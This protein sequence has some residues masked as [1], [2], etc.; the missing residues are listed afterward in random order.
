MEKNQ[1]S[2]AKGQ[3]DFYLSFTLFDLR[4]VIYSYLICFRKVTE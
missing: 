4:F 2:L 1:V 3:N